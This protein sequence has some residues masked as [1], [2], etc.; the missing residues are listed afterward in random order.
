MQKSELKHYPLVMPRSVWDELLD[1]ADENGVSVLHVMQ[2]FIRLGLVVSKLQKPDSELVLEVDG[3]RY[4]TVLF[5]RKGGQAVA[6]SQQEVLNGTAGQRQR[7]AP[8]S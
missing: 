6:S 2:E 3:K 4:P 7:V 8:A 1:I 5:N